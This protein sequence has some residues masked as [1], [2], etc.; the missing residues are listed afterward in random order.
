M[1]FMSIVFSLA[2]AAAP[3]A[4]DPATAPVPAD[5]A[6][7]PVAA[8]PVAAHRNEIMDWRAERVARLQ[9]PDGWLSLVGLHWIE[10]GESTLGSAPDNDIVLATGPA[11]LGTLTSDGKQVTLALAEGVDARIG[12]G[13]DRSG[14][15]ANDATGK[16]TLV[17]FGS[18]NFH[19]IE[20]SG[21]LALRVKDA[22][23][24]TR[25]GFLGLDYYEVDPSFRF[26]ARYI[27]HDPGKTIPIASVIGTLD[28]M[29]NPG[30]VE[31]EKDG[32]RYRL[33]AVDEGDG[34]LFLIFADRT[35]G[36]ETYGAGRFLYAK[37]PAPG[38]DRVVLDFNAAYNPPCV[39]TPHATCPLAPPENRLDLAVTAGEKRYRGEAH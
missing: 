5:S 29:P 14:V 4:A 33:E 25:T 28:P 15:L 24:K 1:P 13:A 10:P 30:A 36:K 20:R 3:A 7:A 32:K 39:F 23:A 12:E 35:S 18:A 17:T 11:R 16:P 38:S 37:P 27:A 34:M 19:V 26:D 6:V 22:N 9:R 2:A 21:R 8:D 31:F